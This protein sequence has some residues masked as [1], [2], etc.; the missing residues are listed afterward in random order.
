MSVVGKE[1]EAGISLSK[2]LKVAAG[3]ALKTNIITLVPLFLPLTEQ[4]RFFI[5][6]VR[7]KLFTANVE[8]QMRS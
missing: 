7:K 1:D 2:D 4:F 5:T 8:T 3:D 6:L